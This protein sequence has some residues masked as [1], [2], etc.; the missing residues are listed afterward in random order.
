MKKLSTLLF[1]ALLFFVSNR[2][3]A[4]TTVI[5]SFMHDNV[6][7]NYRTF[8]PSGFNSSVE[9]P[10]VLNLHGYTSNAEQQELYSEF[11][12]VA[13]TAGVVV[14]YPNGINNSW[15]VN[16]GGVD[17]IGFLDEL[18]DVLKTDYD[19]NL[20]RV[21]VTG[22]SNGGF[23][24]YFLACNLTNRFAAV[25]DVTGSNTTAGQALCSPSKKIPVLHVHGTADPIVPYNGGFGIVSVDDLMNYWRDHN[26]CD[27]IPD[28]VPVPDIVLN[29][30]CTA[31]IITWHN[32]DSSTRVILYRVIGGE[33]TWPGASIPI[34]ITNQDFS[35][36]SVI[37]NFFNQYPGGTSAVNDFPI[38]ENA[39]SIYPN[40]ADQWAVINVQSTVE[41]NAE[42]KVFDLM[43]KEIYT[44]S[45]TANCKL[46]T[47]NW[48]SGVYFVVIS[49]ENSV[50]NSKFVKQ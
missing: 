26:G 8:L 45:F 46:P 1:I 32:C 35:A 3:Q 9:M 37:W 12:D 50:W 34:G 42:L 21:Y 5:D 24:T 27:L 49:S 13:D 22:M 7:R 11:N 20:N 29:D 25:A 28:T 33:H 23:M 38:D 43:G 18:I 36:S 47:A 15:N 39:I 19:I 31:E 17:D 6:W 14:C 44:T 40:P 4:Q 41:E 2:T 30:F 16:V 10:L 48:S